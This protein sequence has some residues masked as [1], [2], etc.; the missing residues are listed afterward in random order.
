MEFGTSKDRVGTAAIG[1]PVFG[2]Y[3][4]KLR[5]RGFT[6]MNEDFLRALLRPCLFSCTLT[7]YPEGR[8]CCGAEESME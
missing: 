8:A 6:Q 5:G 3:T 1:R 2:G 4:N 7:C